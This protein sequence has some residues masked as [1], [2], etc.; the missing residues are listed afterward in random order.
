MSIGDKMIVKS[1]VRK[2]GKLISEAERHTT[3]AIK[4][5]RIEV[6]TT[7]TDY[8]LGEVERIFRQHG[9]I[10]HVIFKPWILRDR[11]PESTEHEFGADFCGVLDIKLR[12]FKY[13][14]G[15]LTQAKMN[16]RGVFIKPS[17][18]GVTS[19]SVST[20][21]ES[22]RLRGQI[23]KMLSLSHESYVIVYSSDGFVVVPATSIKAL[24]GSGSVYG[25]PIDRFF[26]EYLMCFIG[27]PLLKAGDPETLEELRRRTNSRAALM[28]HVVERD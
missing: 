6:E 24:S 4:E 25:K 9:Q 23:D 28:L 8:F 2:F 17:F 18:R 27:D 19:V 26:K 12:D 14:K 22:Q 20:G 15:F 7:I 11:G 10:D 1:I 13:T 21:N 3:E 5:H 16:R